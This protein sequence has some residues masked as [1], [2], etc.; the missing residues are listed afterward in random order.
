M[1]T[2]N[3][4]AKFGCQ[5][6]ACQEIN[7]ITYRKSQ[8]TLSL[9]SIL[10]FFGTL[11]ENW[12]IEYIKNQINNLSILIKVVLTLMQRSMQFR[13]ASFTGSRNLHQERRKMLR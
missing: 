12:N 13:E 9:T 10:S 1:N 5:T 2:C 4:H 7:K 11:T 3:S 6:Q 8:Q